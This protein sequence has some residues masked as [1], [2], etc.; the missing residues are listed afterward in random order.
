MQF[1]A[2]EYFK[3]PDHSATGGGKGLSGF[4]GEEM[5]KIHRTGDS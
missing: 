2:K 5:R 4:R 3:S 1:P